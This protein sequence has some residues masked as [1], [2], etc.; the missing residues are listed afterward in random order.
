MKSLARLLTFP[1]LL[2]ILLAWTYLVKPTDLTSSS[3]S[4]PDP[5]VAK[6]IRMSEQ[7]MSIAQKEAPEAILRQIDTDL[8]RTNFG[9]TDGKGT[10]HISVLVPAPEVP[11]DQWVTQVQS[12]TPLVGR[13]GPALALQNLQIGPNR[14]AQA[15]TAHWS[16][17]TI[18]SLTLYYEE[19][20]LTWAAFCNTSEGV[21]SGVVDNRTGIF[22]PS[23]AP[24]APVPPTATPDHS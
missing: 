16:G 11:P 21:V 2:L 18:R 22:Q 20:H 17:C 15:I 1:L 9:F 24:P 19:D 6:L 13:S 4:S 14:V 5:D 10:R 7:A 3:G 23:H 12:F 8:N